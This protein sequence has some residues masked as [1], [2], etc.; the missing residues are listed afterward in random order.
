MKALLRKMAAA[1][2]FDFDAERMVFAQALQRLLEPGS[3]LQGSKWIGTV[4]DLGFAKLRLEHFYRVLPWLWKKKEV[5]EEALY[6]RRLDLLNQELDLVFFDTTT[7]SRGRASGVGPSSARA[8]TTGRTTCS[9]SS[10]S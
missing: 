8:R 7:T 4:H 3:D 5:I 1:R 6:R 9:S 10:G 2:R